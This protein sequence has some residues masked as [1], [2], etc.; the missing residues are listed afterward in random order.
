M[1]EPALSTPRPPRALSSGH[2]MILG[3]AVLWS[4]GGVFVKI[5]RRDYAMD[6]R[7]IACLRCAAAGLLLAWAL[8]GAV[9]VPKLRALGSSVAYAVVVFTFV[10]A[11]AGTTAA[12][13]IFLQYAYPLFVAV[14]AVFL[15]GERLGRRTVLA[16]ALGMGGVGMILVCSW[17]PGQREGVAYGFASSI[18]FAAFTLIQRWNREGSPVGLSSLYNLAAAAL[19][20]PLAWGH[21]GAPLPALL[22]VAGMGVF[23]LGLPYILFIKGLRSVRAT[24]AALITLVEPILNPVWVW[25][26]VAEAPHW[27]TLVG[28]SLILVGLL[29]RFVAVGGGRNAS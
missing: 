14:A 3:C 16:L 12:N 1:Q 7:A 25:L 17:E 19:M 15:F 13:A 23:Q 9:R 26:A 21:L 24:D 28:G 22:I 5:L 20:L 2:L 8:P 27:S 18:A 4:L 11:T 6:P 10:V 29:A